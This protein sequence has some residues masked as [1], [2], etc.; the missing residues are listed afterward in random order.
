M[1][2]KTPYFIYKPQ[3]L[4]ENYT[5]LATLAQHYLK[6]Y[7]IAYSVKTNSYKPLLK[8]LQILGAHF[9]VASLDEIKKFPRCDIFNGPAKTLQE[10]KKA[11]Q[12]KCLIN[13]DS[14]SELHKLKKIAKNK[15]PINIGIRISC[16]EEKFGFSIAQ[17]PQ[18][19][20]EI[21]N[22]NISIKSLHFHPGTQ[23]NFL[24][25]TSFLKTAAD[26]VNQ[27]DLPSLDSINLGG[28][29]PDKQ[30]LANQKKELEDYVK[31]I[32]EQF[33]KQIKEEKTI[34]LETG[35]ALIADVFELIT[36]V[37]AIKQKDNKKYAILDAG[38]NLL[39]KITLANYRFI[40]IKNNSQKIIEK[41]EPYVLAGPLL[42]G[43]DILTTI[44]EN[45][46]EGDLIK[47]EN[48][49][50]YCYNLAWEISYKRPKI[51]INNDNV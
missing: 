6:K 50:A 28:G 21:K 23:Q 42:F 25:Y 45:L 36:Q 16:K 8:D 48:V 5:R 31:A 26:V 11:I 14:F 43:N 4:K 39:P 33:K 29:L 30:Q 41:K 13:V 15:N 38:I 47:V 49:G 12:R 32:S 24:E 22:E 37:I 40:K 20:D 3:R 51:I 1:N 9:E 10:L 2:K 34:I 46:N 17:L 44:N 27:L 18:L 7:S 35:R 19:L